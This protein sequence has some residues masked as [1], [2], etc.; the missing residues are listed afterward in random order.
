MGISLAFA[1]AGSLGYLSFSVF[2][3][4]AIAAAF[5]R[6]FCFFSPAIFFSWLDEAFILF[7]IKISFPNSVLKEVFDICNA[8]PCLLL[9]PGRNEIRH[10]IN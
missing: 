9:N 8:Q 10:T 6:T 4:V 2:V 1:G 3:I 5:D 7:R